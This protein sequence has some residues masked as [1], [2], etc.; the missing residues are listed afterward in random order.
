MSNMS[1]CRFVNT[2]GDLE[3]CEQDLYDYGLDS[4]ERSESENKY[5][6]KLIEICHR[7]VSEFPEGGNP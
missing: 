7:I 3:D 1:Y 5:A 2:V 6:K 4:D